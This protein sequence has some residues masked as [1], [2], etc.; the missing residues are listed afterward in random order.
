MVIVY[1]PHPKL[2]VG[3][4]TD[5]KVRKVNPI[6]IEDEEMEIPE[7]KEINK[8][9]SSDLLDQHVKCWFNDEFSIIT[10]PEDRNSSN[11]CLISNK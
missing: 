6:T 5:E 7:F 1:C 9:I 3:D 8:F 10:I 11:W 4:I 2:I